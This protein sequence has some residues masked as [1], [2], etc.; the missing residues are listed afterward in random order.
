M[1]RMYA[2]LAIGALMM[3]GGARAC[4]LWAQREAVPPRW[5]PSPL[6]DAHNSSHLDPMAI[7]KRAADTL[8]AT[9]SVFATFSSRYEYP[10]ATENSRPRVVMTVGNS[11]MQR[12]NLDHDWI[13]SDNG[14]STAGARGPSM[15]DVEYSK[16]TS[17]FLSTDTAIYLING[18]TYNRIERLGGPRPGTNAIAIADFFDRAKSPASRVAELRA[19]G[20][21]RFLRLATPERWKGEVYTVVEFQYEDNDPF[22]SKSARKR[23][24]G[25]VL[26]TDERCYI[27]AD[28]L[29]HRIVDHSNLG[30]SQDYAVNQLKL[31]PRLDASLFKIPSS[32]RPLPQRPLLQSGAVAPN[33][34]VLDRYGRAVRLSD[35][36]GK[37]VLLDF[38]A[39]WCIPCQAAFRYV[40]PIAAKYRSQGVVA[41]AVNVWD[42]KSAFDAWTQSHPEF[43]DLTPL[44]D[45]TP[46]RGHNVAS[47]PYHVTGIPTQY[48]IDRDG[49]IVLGVKGIPSE[50]GVVEAAIRSA[51]QR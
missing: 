11:A 25:G 7:L 40:E 19:A 13:W 29:I 14:R 44:I 33:F 18:T 8:H 42:T 41:L 43:N 20:K 26:V 38:W 27:G 9:R 30:W 4:P 3:A 47:G 35:F 23:L 12:P 45:P 37:V 1:K 49:K 24:P 39:S 15:V 6:N 31:D 32:L 5:S 28:R 51:L 21:L 50:P 48:I 36:H 2:A 10:G 46:R 34:R 16:D 22:L 17:Q